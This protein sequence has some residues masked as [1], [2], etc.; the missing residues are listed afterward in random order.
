MDDDNNTMT[1]TT[2]TTASSLMNV[3]VR[4]EYIPNKSTTILLFQQDDPSWKP[5]TT[6]TTIEKGNYH[7]V[8]QYR[9]N[10][11]KQKSN[12]SFSTIEIRHYTMIV[13]DNPGDLHS[14][15]V[16]L[17]IGWDYTY[18]TTWNMDDYEQHRRN[19]TIMEKKKK[20]YIHPIQR[21]HLLLRNGCTMDEIQTAIANVNQARAQRIKTNNIIHS[22]TS[23]L[24]LQQAFRCT[25][26]KLKFLKKKKTIST[27]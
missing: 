12:V 7:N 11:N 19:T 26:K 27:V 14:T 10:N 18:H 17:S 8:N 16:P 24:S 6:T 20:L 23:N 5:T 15:G 9:H 13:G 1:K 21:V 22:I 3:H 4:V 2:T 25:T